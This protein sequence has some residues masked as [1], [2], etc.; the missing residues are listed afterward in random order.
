MSDKSLAN[1]IL[2]RLFLRTAKGIKPGLDRMISSAAFIGNP[3]NSFRS[4]HV[5]GTNG[6]GSVCSYIE[7]A[8]RR[9]GYHTGLFTS[10]HIVSFEERFII[11]GKPVREHE[12]LEVYSCIENA[13]EQFDLTFFE[14]STLLAFELFKR[15][16]IEVAVIETG[17]GGRLDATNIISPVVSVITRLG[18]DHTE[19]LG[20]DLL[21]IAGEK[22]GIVKKNVPVVMAKPQQQEITA[23]ANEIC[24]K[25]GSR[26]VIADSEEISSAAFE[27]GQRCFSYRGTGYMVGLTGKYQ[28]ANAVC[29]INALN[30]SGLCLRESIVSGL[31]KTCLPGRFDVRTISGKQVVFDVGH[32]V[33]ALESLIESLND[34][35]GDKSILFV[36]GIMKD[37][38]TSGM[39][40]LLCSRAGHIILSM[41][42]TDRASTAEALAGLVPVSFAGKMEIIPEVAMA[43]KAAMSG[44]YGI[45][46]VTGSFYTVGEAMM[47]MNIEPYPFR[48]L[49]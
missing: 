20:P 14:A 32:N 6:K 38:D 9:E 15:A 42:H 26:L 16:G 37:K 24:S 43:I 47:E 44:P 1:S 34:V 48:G 33:Q 19:Y 8:L 23:L 7:S 12:W 28:P 27:S 40:N 39:I 22:L 2:T 18:M 49:K 41:P 36:T 46:C 11:N 10:P 45:I 3:Q 30:E 25:S 4:F 35:F 21:S 5:A 17:M 13:V 29:A 31:K